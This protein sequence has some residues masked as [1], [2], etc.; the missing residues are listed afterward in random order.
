[1]N[2]CIG[3]RNVRLFHAFVVAHAIMT[4]YVAWLLLRL[5]DGVLERDRV[6]SS[7][8]LDASSGAYQPVRDMERSRHTQ[9]QHV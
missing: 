8:Y 9:R 2:N 6:W 1:M 5:A 3:A 4:A 7:R